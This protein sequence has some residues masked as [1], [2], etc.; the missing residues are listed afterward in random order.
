MCLYKIYSYKA[1]AAPPNNR[2]SH[3]IYVPTLMLLML[4]DWVCVWQAL[5]FMRR[6]LEHFSF[7]LTLF[8]W[9]AVAFIHSDISIKWRVSCSTTTNNIIFSFFGRYIFVFISTWYILFSNLRF[10]FSVY[11]N[12]N[13]LCSILRDF[14]LIVWKN[15]SCENMRIL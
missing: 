7:I 11:F 14:P 9:F 10:I 1:P 15:R 12:N 5:C 8:R 13:E 2:H 6:S 3:H 4:Y